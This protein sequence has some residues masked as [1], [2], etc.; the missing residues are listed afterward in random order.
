MFLILLILPTILLLYCNASIEK[1]EGIK[2]P[3]IM[4]HS[5]LKEQARSGKYTISPEILKQ[6]LEYIKN[7]G[8]I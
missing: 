7:N 6:D 3:I 8:Y 4:Y 1:E 5:L 2:L